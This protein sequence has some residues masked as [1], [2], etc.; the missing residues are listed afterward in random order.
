MA[1]GKVRDARTAG[2][3]RCARV[4]PDLGFWAQQEEASWQAQTSHTACGPAPGASGG[5]VR[6]L[7]A[8]VHSLSACS[9]DASQVGGGSAA[10]RWTGYAAALT[11]VEPHAATATLVQASGLARIRA[12]PLSEAPAESVR[13]RGAAGP[14]K[15]PA[16]RARLFVSGVAAMGGPGGK[17]SQQ[18]SGGLRSRGRGAGPV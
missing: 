1:P 5:Q 13:A 10:V 16:A 2:Q 17:P 4:W 8:C 11:Q 3:T 9:P 18:T 14:G 7:G 12:A 15:A 6:R